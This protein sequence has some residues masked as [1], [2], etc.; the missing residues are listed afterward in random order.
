MADK[1]VFFYC[2]LIKP[3]MADS[4]KKNKK[5]PKKPKSAQNHGFPVFR[6]AFLTC[7]LSFQ[8][9]NRENKLPQSYQADGFVSR[10]L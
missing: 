7:T 3:E 5:Q 4:A 10:M 9:S 8:R 6:E 1:R 2:I